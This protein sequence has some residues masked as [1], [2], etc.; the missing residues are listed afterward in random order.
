LP[1]ERVQFLYET[2][3]RTLILHS[4]E[5]VYPGPYTYKRF[6]FRDAAFIIHALLCAGLTGRAERALDRF[7]ERQTRQG[8]FHSQ[9]GEWDSNG[10]ALWIMQ[11]F[12][13]LTGQPPKHAWRQ[14]IV[15]GARWITKKRLADNGDS[16]H[17]GLLPAGFSAEHL[18]P[19]DYYY[20]DD[21]WGVAGL[22]SAAALGG[23][24]GDEALQTECLNDAQAFRKAVDRSLTRAARRLDRPVI[25]ASPYRRMDAGAIGSLAAGYPLQLCPPDDPQLLGTIEFLMENC[26]VNGGFFQDMIHA[27]INP[28]LT[29]HMAQV[30]LRAGD[31]RYLELMDTVAALATSTGQWPEAIHPRTGGGCMGDGQHVW[32]AAEWLLM[33]RNCFVRE[34]GDR[35]ILGAGVAQCWMVAGSPLTFGPVPTTFGPLTLTIETETNHRVH[36]TW[37]GSWHATEPAIEV[38][39]PGFAPVI[40]KPGESSVYIERGQ[41]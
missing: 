17:A 32:A 29:L 21:F 25:P 22:H 26:R 24:M 20:W 36:V 18:G 39:I 4:P 6:W 34:E 10:Q 40:A 8:Y 27:G 33:V 3:L 23:L 15:R 9:E 1:D 37:Q 31:P 28:Y 11:R 5:D 2:A 35:F 30:L 41:N 13:A 16:P 7:P 38:R 14:A 12:C 19:N